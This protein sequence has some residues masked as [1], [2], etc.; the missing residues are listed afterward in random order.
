MSFVLT[1]QMCAICLTGHVNRKLFIPSCWEREEEQTTLYRVS[2]TCCLFPKSKIFLCQNN[3]LGNCQ[4]TQVPLL[5]VTQSE[6]AERN[7]FC[8]RK[9]MIYSAPAVIRHRQPTFSGF[10][11][12]EFDENRTNHGPD[13][14]KV[15]MKL[16]FSAKS[17]FPECRPRC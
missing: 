17:L 1:V 2:Y 11:E 6:R 3:L 16:F 13:G 8:K 12:V 9:Q 4:F 15:K 14:A 5:Y 7:K 10:G